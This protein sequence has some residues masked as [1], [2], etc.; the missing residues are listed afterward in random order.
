MPPATRFSKKIA[1]TAKYSETNQKQIAKAKKKK[2]N[3]K[4]KAIDYIRNGAIIEQSPT[5]Y[6]IR[7][8][9]DP[10]Q[11]YVVTNTGDGWSCTCPRQFGGTDTKTCSHTRI[12]VE[13]QDQKYDEKI[14][15]HIKDVPEDFNIS[16]CLSDMLNV[17]K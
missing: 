6:V 7:S 9:R 5:K 12:P 11:V 14:T 1:M 13:A 2:I 15:E 17:K 16:D 4:K 3:A 8:Q 10:A